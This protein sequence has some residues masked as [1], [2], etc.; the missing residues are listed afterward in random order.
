MER[1]LS[2]SIRDFGNEKEELALRDRKRIA[3]M[4]LDSAGL[5]QL[6]KLKSKEL[7]NV[8]KLA[9]I[10][11][12]KRNEVET[13]L[14]EAIEQVKEEIGK[15]R[16]DEERGSA[17]FGRSSSKLPQL[18]P[19]RPSNLPTSA[20]ERVDIRDLTWEDRERVL[21]LLFAKINNSATQKP[22]PH[23]ALTQPGPA[24]G[25]PRGMVDATLLQYPPTGES[26][27]VGGYSQS[28]AS[29]DLP[30]PHDDM[31]MFMTQP[32]VA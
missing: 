30:F 23:H 19:A 2:T 9:S 17:R 14:L 6:V 26:G 27:S 18:G 21:R 25:M 24:A 5:R 7:A 28:Q 22:M 15:Q 32:G 13:F 4:E 12:H 20:D 3:E 8:K 11:L 16:A 10:I 31:A 29:P 1:S